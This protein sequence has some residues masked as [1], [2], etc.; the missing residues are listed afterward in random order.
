[1]SPNW[2][3]KEVFRRDARFHPAERMRAKRNRLKKDYFVEEG[4]RDGGY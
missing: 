2:T 1:M 4:R 3:S